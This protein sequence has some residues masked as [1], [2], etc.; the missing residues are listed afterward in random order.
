MPQQWVAYRKEGAAFLPD[1][2]KLGVFC[3]YYDEVFYQ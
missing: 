3:G 2:K 1:L